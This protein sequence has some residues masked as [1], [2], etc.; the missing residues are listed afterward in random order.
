MNQVN[1]SEGRK[2]LL[3]IQDFKYSY[4]GR[5]KIASREQEYSMSNANQGDAISSNSGSFTK[6][7]E[8][9]WDIAEDATSAL[10]VNDMIKFGFECV[11]NDNP[12]TSLFLQFRAY[13][14]AGITDNHQASYNAFKY[15]GR[16]EDFFTY[17]G[18]SRTI[19][20]GFRVAVE[21]SKDL[22]PIYDK[23]NALASQ[24]YPDYST[25]NIMRTSL[26]KLTVGDY[27]R[28]M[29]GILESVNITVS[30]D[31]SWEIE[32]NYQLP[33]Y[34]D[35]T[36]TFKPIHEEL[37]ERVI[38]QENLGNK[39]RILYNVKDKTKLSNPT[40]LNSDFYKSETPEPA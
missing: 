35:V 27:M 11:N 14:T 24:V 28:R 1:G 17:Q 34:V 16:G 30:Q 5:Y 2:V 40:T 9:P 31:S 8:D 18:F 32:D 23:L 20:F 15:L 33:H 6:D 22:V 10:A 12:S 29:P 36:I 38:T 39:N 19:N 25:N 37:P 13:L 21:N 3:D 7:N 26:I 4:N